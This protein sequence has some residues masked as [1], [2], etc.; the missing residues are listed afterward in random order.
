MNVPIFEI[1]ALNRMSMSLG[2]NRM[3]EC[4]WVIVE[5]WRWGWYLLVFFTQ[6]IEFLSVVVIVFRHVLSN[7]YRVRMM[8]FSIMEMRD[9]FSQWDERC[10]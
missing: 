7:F 10:N 2:E 8:T 6:A 1:E 4:L 3:Q 5:H 9:D